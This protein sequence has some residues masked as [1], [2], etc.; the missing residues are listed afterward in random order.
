[1]LVSPWFPQFPKGLLP[2]PPSLVLSQRA[3][4][5][6]QDT[7]Y[8][9]R[10]SCAGLRRHPT[11]AL[12][13]QLQSP[14]GCQSRATSTTPFPT[15]F[16]LWRRKKTHKSKSCLLRMTLGESPQAPHLQNGMAWN[17]R[18]CAS[19]SRGYPPCIPGS[20]GVTP[21]PL[22]SGAAPCP[23][24]SPLSGVQWLHTAR[25]PHGAKWKLF[26]SPPVSAC[27]EHRNSGWT[28]A[29]FL[30]LLSPTPTAP[31]SL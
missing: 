6:H 20:E 15:S 30:P 8:A 5:R 21:G 24:P 4:Q 17:G 31:Q 25:C 16:V 26:G 13:G 29:L 10:S 11:R 27:P 1:M 18:G 7:A 19:D 22:V 12:P 2:T 14:L 9:S 3:G 28:Q 23:P